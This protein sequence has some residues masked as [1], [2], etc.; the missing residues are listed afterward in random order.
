MDAQCK[1]LYHEVDCSSINGLN[2]DPL[3]HTFVVDSRRSLLRRV[4]FEAIVIEQRQHLIG[5][6]DFIPPC[7][8]YSSCT[9]SLCRN[10]TSSLF[11]LCESSGELLIDVIQDRDLTPAR[12]SRTIW[13][14]VCESSKYGE[15][16]T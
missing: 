12:K 8:S 9:V 5:Q 15:C 13:F 14:Q 1:A 6:S 3:H 16:P 2:S 10:M 4:E 7:P 11:L